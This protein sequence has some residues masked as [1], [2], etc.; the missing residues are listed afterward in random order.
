MTEYSER[1]YG[2]ALSNHADFFG[3]LEYVEATGAQRVVT[4]N[5]R[6]K[7]VELAREIRRRLGIDAVPSSNFDSREWGG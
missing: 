4:D 5:T 2:I 6:G 3:T 7:G 1:S